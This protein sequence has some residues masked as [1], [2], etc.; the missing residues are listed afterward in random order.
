VSVGDLKVS[1]IFALG[2]L[3]IDKVLLTVPN[4]EVQEVQEALRSIILQPKKYIQ[5]AT[6]KEAELKSLLYQVIYT[7]VVYPIERSSFKQRKSPSGPGGEAEDE[8]NTKSL[9]A[10]RRNL[11]DFPIIVDLLQK[12][13]C[14]YKVR[15]GIRYSNSNDKHLGEFVDMLLQIID[16]KEVSESVKSGLLESFFKLFFSKFQV[17]EEPAKIVDAI[18]FH[19]QPD[20][21]CKQP[22]NDGL[23]RR[24]KPDDGLVP[25]TPFCLWTALHLAMIDAGVP[26]MSGEM[27]RQK[28]KEQCLGFMLS[29]ERDKTAKFKK[30]FEKMRF[31]FCNES[32]IIMKEVGV[33]DYYDV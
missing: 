33:S 31:N 10:I 2:L 14:E 11:N 21:K 1:P 9:N 32:G 25:N 20:F 8:D 5:E 23:M 27:D 16:A 18:N 19:K 28:I 24:D 29:D 30:E 7:N 15:P 4:S 17:A 26:E 3:L 13:M 12:I 22:W 6:C